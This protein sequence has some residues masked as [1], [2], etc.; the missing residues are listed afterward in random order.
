MFS[1]EQIDQFYPSFALELYLLVYRL[2]YIW[3]FHHNIDFVSSV[4]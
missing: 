3:T 4:T 1:I 2:P